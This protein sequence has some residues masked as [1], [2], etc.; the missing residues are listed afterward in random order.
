MYVEFVHMKCPCDYNWGKA[1]L[2][3]DT[4]AAARAEGCDIDCDAYPYA[5]GANPL[6][7]LLPPWVQIGDKGTMLARLALPEVRA[8]VRSELAECG[9]NNWGRIASWEA[10]RISI[11]PRL[12]ETARQT[13]GALAR[14]RGCEPVDEI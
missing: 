14:A 3:L 5:A 12:P 1:S 4:I 11:S 8:R 2:I 10:V 7:N 9:L 13:V 6:K